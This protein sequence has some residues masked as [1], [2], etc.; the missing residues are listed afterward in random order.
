[1]QV[2]PNP[3]VPER[4]AL[5]LQPEALLEPLFGPQRDPAVGGHD[6]MPR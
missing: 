6:A 5:D 3:A 1:V 2:H 4:N